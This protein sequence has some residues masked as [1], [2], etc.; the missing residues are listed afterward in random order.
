MSKSQAATSIVNSIH[1]F[2]PDL[3]FYELS[4]STMF[5]FGKKGESGLAEDRAITNSQSPTPQDPEKA[6]SA[7]NIPSEKDSVFKSLGWLDQ[8]LAV[9]I[10][11]AMIIGILLGNFVP[12]TGPALQKGQ[13]VR[14]SIPIGIY[15][16]PSTEY[17][18]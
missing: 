14:V 4:P 18:S 5:G 2:H 7:R 1:L 16:L 13:F 11:L 8:F 6:D 12:N 10:L 9:W 17:K 15:T 3:E